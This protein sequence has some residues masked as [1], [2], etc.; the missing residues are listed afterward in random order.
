MNDI[1]ND[2]NTIYTKSSNN[3]ISDDFLEE[4]NNTTIIVL[5]LIVAFI[6]FCVFCNRNEDRDRQ[7]MVERANRA[8]ARLE[9]R[10]GN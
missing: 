2:N 1:V 7:D 10:Y 8:Q 3:T 6:L 5:S 4:D 9:I